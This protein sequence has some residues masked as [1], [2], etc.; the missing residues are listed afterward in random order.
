MPKAQEYWV[1]QLL[2]AKHGQESKPYGDYTSQLSHIRHEIERVLLHAKKGTQ[3]DQLFINALRSGS[4][5]TPNEA[6][7]I[8]G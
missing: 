2:L 4:G 1:V 8:A 6:L 5:Q 3:H 7:T